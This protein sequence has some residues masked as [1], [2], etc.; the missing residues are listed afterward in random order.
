MPF[1]G[2]L[3]KTQHLHPVENSCRKK[4]FYQK[5]VIEFPSKYLTQLNS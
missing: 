2:L 4:N 1:Y 3:I 5:E